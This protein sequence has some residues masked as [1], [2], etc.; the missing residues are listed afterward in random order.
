[1]GPDLTSVASN[2]SV[3]DLLRAI[4]EPSEVIS[5]QY[6]SHTVVAQ[7]GR[8]AMG[9]L[10]EGDAELTIYPRSLSQPPAIFDRSEVASVEESTVSQ[11]PAG[12]VNGLNP[13]ELADLVA[14]LIS[15]GDPDDEVFMSEAQE[16]G[17]E[18]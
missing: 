6:G 16:G 4:V 12:L 9:M 13:E 1:M 11:M 18:G 3:P 8:S 5:D 15:G 2:F 14:Y 7:D 17:D 10:V